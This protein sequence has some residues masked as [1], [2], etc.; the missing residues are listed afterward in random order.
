[1]TIPTISTLPVA[2]ARTDAPATFV[3]RADSFLAA[4]VVMQSELNTTIGS[5]NTDIASTNTNV[6]LAS[7]WAI[8]NDAAVTG[9]DWSAYA[10][11]VGASPTGSAK[12]WSIE[13]EDVVVADGEYSS[14]HYSIKSA[15]SAAAASTSETNAATS[16][17]NSENSAI[18]SLASENAAAA[19][20]DAF[21]DRYLGAKASDP[22]LDNDGNAL[23]TGAQY[24]NTTNDVTRVYNGATWQDSAAVA[25]S[26]TVAQISDLDASLDSFL[27]QDGTSA[28]IVTFDAG[29]Y[30]AGV[31]SDKVIAL[32]DSGT[33]KT[34]TC[35]TGSVFTTTLTGSCTFTLSTPNAVAGRATSFTLI[36]TNDA[37]ADR[38]IAFAG[39]T[40]KYPGGSVTRSTEANAVDLWFFFSPDGGTTWF[41][42]LPAKNFTT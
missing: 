23:Q 21:D 39:G 32:G 38:T 35:N 22:T 11:A 12:D 30:F 16:A 5:M 25:S 29:N 27:K 17:T 28:E 9:T 4:I 42:T 24:F 15:A 37:T 33:A 36:V 34:I 19:T 8:K 7:E 14:K 20:Y 31:F 41:V 26:V 1:M 13:A 40:F 6:T 10:N 3:T 18:A 2:P